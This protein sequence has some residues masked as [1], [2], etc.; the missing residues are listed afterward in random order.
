MGGVIGPNI[1]TN[2]LILSLDASNTSS[3][4]GSGTAIY[5]LSEKKAHATINGTVPYVG[6]G[7]SSYWN[8]ATAASTKFISS[9]LSQPYLD[10]TIVFYPDF[11]L[12]SNAGLVGLIAASND[13]TNTDKSMRFKNAN[14]TG[15][16]QVIGSTGINT[17][18]WGNPSTTYYVNGSAVADGAS[19]NNG[20]N[21]LG[22]YRSNQS[23]FPSSFAYHL[24]TEGFSSAVRD[25]Q[26]RIAMCLMYNRQLSAAE[27]ARNYNALRKRFGL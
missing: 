13:A 1:V 23:T 22:A 16:W 14:G 12:N 21:I 7:S 20:W 4:P 3:Y 24:G 19:L 26:G 10:C 2:G 25:F 11:T 27:H 18:D 6:A 17:D 15:P 8:F 5:D 9:T